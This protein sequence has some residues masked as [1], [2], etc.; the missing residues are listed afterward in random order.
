MVQI[1]LSLSEE[2]E[3]EL[4]KLAIEKYDGKKGALS[5]VVE[6]GIDL[7]K[8][9]TNQKKADKR[10]WDMVNNAKD[11]GKIEFTREEANE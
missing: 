11:L 8:N 1:V 7:V 2:K 5:K 10:F 6:D 9:Q 3:K 4:R